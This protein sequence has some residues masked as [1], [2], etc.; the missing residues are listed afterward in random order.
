MKNITI[1]LYVDRANRE[2]H[3]FRESPAFGDTHEPRYNPL[4]RGVLNDG[5]HRVKFGVYNAMLSIEQ[6]KSIAR[7][8][9]SAEPV[10]A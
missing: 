7:M 2:V 10:P 5:Q 4:Q 9:L 8:A 1:E 3:V 6:I